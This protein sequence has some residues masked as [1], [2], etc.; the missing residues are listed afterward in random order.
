[1]V[2]LCVCI[3]ATRFCLVAL[4]EQVT[5]SCLVAQIL[6]I[7]VICLGLYMLQAPVNFLD[8]VAFTG[9]KYVALNIN[10]ILGIT[11]GTAVY[12]VAM[13][14]TGLSISYFVL[15]SIAQAVKRGY[16]V[17]TGG[18]IRPEFVI[19]G[20]AGLQFLS[21]WWLGYAGDLKKLT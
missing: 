5:S 21:V 1:M 10:M 14:Y 7:A 6:E 16:H 9:Y 11:M 18:P 13:L 3:N 2:N 15:K 20:F 12:T 4:L 17:P 8:L 19:L